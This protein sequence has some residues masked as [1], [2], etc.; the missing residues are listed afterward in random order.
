MRSLP[1]NAWNYD[2]FAPQFGK[3]KLKCAHVFLYKPMRNG[4]PCDTIEFLKACEG[5]FVR[6]ACAR[7]KERWPKQS[8]AMEWWA[9]ESVPLS[10]TCTASGR[11][12]RPHGAV[13]RMFQP[14]RGTQRADG[15]PVAG[16]DA[17]RVYASYA[18]MA[19][20]EAAREDGIDFVSIVTPNDSHYEIAK[21]FLQAGVHIVCEKPLCLTA[22]QAQEL[23]ALARRNDCLFAV[24]YTY[25]GYTMSRVMRQM[26]ADGAIGEIVAVN[27]EYAQ[28]WL[29]DELSPQPQQGN[30]VWRMD[31][32][33]SG[34]SNCVADIGT[35]IACF[36]HYVT[37]LPIRRVAATVN[38][39][40]RLLDLNA[41]IL[42]EY[43][44]GVNGAYWCSQVAAG[45]ANGLV[46]RVYGTR[47]SLQWHQETPDLLRFAP[48]GEPVRVL[49][50]GGHG[51]PQPAGSG[52][53][54]PV[55]HP[56]GLY[57]AFCQHLPR[58]C[59]GVAA[60]TERPSL[61]YGQPDDD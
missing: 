12:G 31:P 45:H 42:V 19:S 47:G 52:S 34:T 21:A 14:K 28:D 9:E 11:D 20:A 54:L 55:G 26:I 49:E 48:K 16:L 13:R 5:P 17:E 7:R 29:L 51:V 3:K 24:S 22:A 57:V 53:R 35:H 61:R 18:A 58:L 25:P 39:Y 6:Q 27:A 23:S 56:E 43:E 30:Y 2:D 60:K 1:R 50:R 40:G 4:A 44:N 33:V 32:A 36:V 46:V 59:A 10:G 37:G 38:R 15:L 41:N 8:F